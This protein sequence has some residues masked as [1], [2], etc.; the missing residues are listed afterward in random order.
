MLTGACLPAEN[1]WHVDEDG[2]AGTLP[3]INDALSELAIGQAGT[4]VV[5]ES[6]SG[7]T[8]NNV[9]ISGARTVALLAATGESP[10]HNGGLSTT[11]TVSNG[12][13]VFVEG[14]EVRGAQPLLIDDAV[15]VLDRSTI[16]GRVGL[17]TG[18]NLLARNSI[19]NAVTVDGGATV[20]LLYST[21]VNEFG[22]SATIECSEEG[23]T[24]VTIRNSLLLALDDSAEPITAACDATIRYSASEESLGGSTNTI[25]GSMNGASW[26]VNLD[27]NDFHLA[28]PPS[29]LLTAARWQAGDPTTDIDGTPR[30]T[31]DGTPDVAGAHR[32][33][34]GE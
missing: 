19:I 33:V 25:L 26:F 27:D 30:P 17:M 1:V 8:L 24:G 7:Q 34:Q 3:T 6:D 28:N 29:S 11:V 20:D 23:L 12:A 9:I 18:A 2:G 21:V 14:W 32:L 31:T 13:T 16:L 5:H 10:V 22:P 15:V 4:I